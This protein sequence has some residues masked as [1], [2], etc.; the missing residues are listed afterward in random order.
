MGEIERL[1]LLASLALGNLQWLRPSDDRFQG[2]ALPGHPLMWEWC[3]S[4]RGEP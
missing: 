4:I 1:T 3:F 2:T